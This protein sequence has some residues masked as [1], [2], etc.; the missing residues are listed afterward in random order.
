[1]AVNVIKHISTTSDQLSSIEVVAGQ[2]IFCR[3]DRTIHLD[4]STGRCDYN[5]IIVLTT[6]T[7]RE[8]IAT[9]VNN[10]FYFCQETNV[11][12]RYDEG[13]VALTATPNEQVFFG[14]KADF[15]SVGS[16]KVL[17]VSGTE[18]YRWLENNYIRMGTGSYP[19]WDEL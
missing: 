11:F 18:M 13:W 9:P 15:P 7:Q 2:L 12:W 1:M 3:D 19:E 6:E 5:Q 17:Y 10:A 4:D 8:A 16:E 14:A